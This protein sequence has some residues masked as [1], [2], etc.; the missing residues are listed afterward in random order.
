MAKERKPSKRDIENF[1]KRAHAVDAIRASSNGID[2][3][4][5][6]EGWGNERKAKVFNAFVHMVRSTFKPN[7]QGVRL[8]MEQGGDKLAHIAS[9]VREAD[10]AT[11]KRR[12]DRE[13]A[14]A[15]AAQP[16][17]AERAEHQAPI[18]SST[19]AEAAI[20]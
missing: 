17:A 1:E 3:A 14:K 5:R 4:A 10:A 20:N 8:V 16:T 15:L 19:D 12:L 13:Q 11:A 18:L 6:K 7:K 9:A 2:H